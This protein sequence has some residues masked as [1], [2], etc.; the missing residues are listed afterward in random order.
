M[1]W[2]DGITD[3]MDTSLGKLW[4]IVKYRETWCAAIQAVPKSL[5]RQHDLVTER[6][7]KLSHAAAAAAAKSLQSCS[8]L[9][10]PIDGSPLGSPVPGILQARTQEWAA[11]SF[12]NA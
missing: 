2:L 1:R 12:S 11:I 6:Q 7:Q 3:S 5:T 9:C 4:E 8:T 10:D